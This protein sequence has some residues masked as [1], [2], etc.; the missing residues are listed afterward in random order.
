MRRKRRRRN[1][2]LRNLFFVIIVF[3]MLLGLLFGCI[4]FFISNYLSSEPSN[5]SNSASYSTEEKQNGIVEFFNN[6]FGKKDEDEKFKD[7]NIYISNIEDG[8]TFSSGATIKLQLK[9]KDIFEEGNTN[10]F[11]GIY[12]VN[13]ETYAYNKTIN[14]VTGEISEEIIVETGNLKP[15]EYYIDAIISDINKDDVD[16]VDSG[17]VYSITINIE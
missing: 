16:L 9:A 13:N 11:L 10:I 12:D 15:G 4:A 6:I 2:S 3:I 5:V 14:N 8:Q 7:K 17:C 1:S